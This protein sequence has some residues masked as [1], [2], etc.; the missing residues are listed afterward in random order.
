MSAESAG[1]VLR[2]ARAAKG[3]N[4][5]QTAMKAR[6]RPVSYSKLERG[7]TT[8]PRSDVVAR[9]LAVLGVPVGEWWAEFGKEAPCPK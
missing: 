1:V 8:N 4:Q 9:I 2:V 7:L 6:C 3:L 5:W